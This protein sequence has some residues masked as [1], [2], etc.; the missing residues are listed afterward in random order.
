MLSLMDIMKHV[1]NLKKMRNDSTG[2]R[3]KM[4]WITE[5]PSTKRWRNKKRGDKLVTNYGNSDK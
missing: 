4:G 3:H 5:K 2:W 1:K